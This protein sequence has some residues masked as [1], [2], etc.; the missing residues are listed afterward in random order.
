LVVVPGPGHAALAHAAV[1]L[2]DAD[3]PRSLHLQQHGVERVVEV[4]Q[5]LAARV[6]QGHVEALV[7]LAARRQLR[8]EVAGQQAGR[9]VATHP[10]GLQGLHQPA[11]GLQGVERLG[12]QLAAPAQ[13]G[14][15]RLLA[16]LA[17]LRPELLDGVAAP[18]RQIG[19]AR[20]PPGRRLTPGQRGA[21]QQRPE[22]ADVVDPG[23]IPARARRLRGHRGLGAAF[24]TP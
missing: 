5:G 15:P 1:G 12:G 22:C 18:V 21:Q 2:A 20:W 14:R 7:A 9:V 24:Q 23:R 13:P 17:Q 8:L 19:P 3:A 16:L 10:V 4:E 11:M 6:E